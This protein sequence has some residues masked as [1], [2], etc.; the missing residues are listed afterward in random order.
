[1]FKRLALIFSLVFLLAP[2]VANAESIIDFGIAGGGTISW[3]GN[4]S[5][6][7]IGSNIAIDS[8]TGIGTP[9]NDGVTLTITDGFLNFVTG[10][11]LGTDSSH[12]YFS[13]GGNIS[14]TGTI[15]DLGIIDGNLMYNGSW[16]DAFVTAQ[17]DGRAVASGDYTDTK[18]AILAAFYGLGP[19]DWSGTLNPSFCCVPKPQFPE[20]NSAMWLANQADSNAKVAYSGG[21]QGFSG[22]VEGG[23]VINVAPIPEPASLTLIGTGLIGLA[24]MARRKLF[25]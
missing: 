6:S 23:D 15:T 2:V 18:N 12:W 7:L 3:D 24:G 25:S 22:T 17:G 16:I 19:N 8:V 11:F 21:H 14:I 1:M 13:G 5:H 10:S 9:L 20:S 4:P